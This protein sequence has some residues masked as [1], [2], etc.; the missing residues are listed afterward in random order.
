MVV[1]LGTPPTDIRPGFQVVRRSEG[2]MVRVVTLTVAV[3][4]LVGFAMLVATTWY[5]PDVAGAVYPPEELTVP[6]AA[7]S[8]TDQVTAVDWPAVVPATTAVNERVPPGVVSV[9]CGETAT[10]TPPPA[11]TVTVAVSVLEGSAMLAATTWKVPVIAGAVYV[12]EAS[13]IPPPTSC[14]DQRT[15]AELPPLTAAA[16]ERVALMARAACC[17]VTVTETVVEEPL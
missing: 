16:K 8:C 14:T 10:D 9:A 3:P 13:T 12:P 6:P 7:P 2:M 5:V 4:L 1:R 11:A 17:G 15:S